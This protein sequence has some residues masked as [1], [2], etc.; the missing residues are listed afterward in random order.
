MTTIPTQRPRSLISAIV[1]SMALI[2]FASTTIAADSPGFVRD[3]TRGG[4]ELGLTE[5]EVTRRI[6]ATESLIAQCMADAG[7][8]YSPVDYATARAA[9]DSNSKPSGLTADEFR[10]QFGYGIT[11]RVSGPE[12]Q[13]TMSLGKRNAEYRNGLA[14][15]DRVAYDRTLYGENPNSTF[16]VALDREDFSQVGG[17][18]RTAVEAIFSK[19]ELGA[20]FVN[21]QNE[22][23]ARVAA[24]PRVIAAY[25]DWIACM[26]DA[27][28]AYGDPSEIRTDLASR[29]EAIV[30]ESSIDSLSEAAASALSDLQSQ[31][32]ALAAADHACDLQNVADIK[33][34]VEAEIL[35]PDAQP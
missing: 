27:G 33:R 14:T 12:T 25:Q 30:G 32:I 23:G 13:A 9:M 31:E 16:I 28:Y 7:F 11:T 6:D 5:H 2:A 34:Q 20:S 24:D 19:D 3:D 10:E 8:E 35:G 4:E 18:T 17:C 21:Y 29:F 26:R 22:A 15:A 1:A